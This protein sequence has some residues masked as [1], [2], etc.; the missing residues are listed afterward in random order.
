M[1]EVVVWKHQIIIGLIGRLTRLSI[2]QRWMDLTALVTR[3]LNKCNFLLDTQ[4]N[5]IKKHETI[6]PSFAINLWQENSSTSVINLLYKAIEFISPSKLQKVIIHPFTLGWRIRRHVD[7]RHRM[8][9]PTLNIS[10]INFIKKLLVRFGGW[11][12]SYVGPFYRQSCAKERNSMAKK[13]E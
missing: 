7:T 4:I 11:K 8:L 10:E 13:I 1:S 9:S 5:W 2:S 3:L 12:L 6:F